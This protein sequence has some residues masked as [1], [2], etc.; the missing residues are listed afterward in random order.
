MAAKVKK[1]DK[2][3]ILTGKDK[4]RSGEVI[5]VIPDEDRVLVRGIN[6]MKRHT[7][8]SQTDP[9][10]GIKVKE[11]PI[12]ISNVALTDPKSGKPTRVGFM[13]KDGRKMRVARKSGVA[14]DG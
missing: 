6:Q 11:A 8:P 7:K 2:V 9:Q 10:G 14:I 4:G 3:V 5:R 13:E 12:H 1:G